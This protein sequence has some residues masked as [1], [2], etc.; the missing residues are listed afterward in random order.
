MS[1]LLTHGIW[2]RI[3]H[4]C[5]ARGPRFVAVPFIGSGAARRLPLKKGDMLVCR[6]DEA[7]VKV[8]VVDPRELGK[9][10]RRGVRVFAA[11]N[12]HAKVFVFP[13]SVVVGSSNVSASSESVLIEAGI[14]DSSATVV[15]HAREFVRGL[16]SDE[17]GSEFVR[18][19]LPLYRPPRAGPAAGRRKGTVAHAPLA[20]VSLGVD[21]YDDITE[22]AK[23]LALEKARELQDDPDGF[24]LQTFDW[25]GA[26]PKYAKRGT[27]VV[28]VVRAS[29][30]LYFEPPGRVIWTRSY[31]NAR[32]VASTIFCVEVPRRV[33]T[34][35]YAQIRSALGAD[36]ARLSGVASWRRFAD[37]NLVHKIGQ[38][39]AQ[40]RTAG[41]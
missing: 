14:E 8:G 28:Q 37:G 2:A 38:I 7:S 21:S 23:N 15:S 34:R 13:R 6:C 22:A 30:K 25:S 26:V 24:A 5:K 19:L 1:R 33:R 27:R 16:A 20:V 31:K 4:L 36:A 35:N 9:Y 32:G 17:V 12:L 18:R 11:A 39:W 41:A 3:S 10:L 40:R 29:G